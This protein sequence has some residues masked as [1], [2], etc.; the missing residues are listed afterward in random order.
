MRPFKFMILI[1][2]LARVRDPTTG[3]WHQTRY[4]M[5]A[6]DARERFGEGNYEIR[7]WSTGPRNWMSRL[8]WLIEIF[9]AR[10]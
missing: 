1:P 3:E 8:D 9:S 7:D 6:E 10:R 2:Y 4:R 5:T